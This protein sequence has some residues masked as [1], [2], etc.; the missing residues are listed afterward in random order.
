MK[1]FARVAAVV[2]LA[3]VPSAAQADV[4]EE[5]FRLDTFED[6]VALCGVEA[7]DPN[8]TAAVHMCHGYVIGLTHFHILVGRSL[9][10]DVYCIEEGERPTRDE[11]VRMLVDWSKSHP[12]HDS[13]EAIDGVL[14]WAADVYPCSE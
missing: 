8:A 13:K 5:N 9:E 7:G 4:T 12:E 2:A 10:G 1:R 14:H 3:I 6:L 11:A